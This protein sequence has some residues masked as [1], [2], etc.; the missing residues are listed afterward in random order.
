MYNIVIKYLYTS[1]IDHPWILNS[2][3]LFN[4]GI[5]CN[6]FIGTRYQ[7]RK[8]QPRFFPSM[9]ALIFGVSYPIA[10]TTPDVTNGNFCCYLGKGR[11]G[12]LSK[13]SMSPSSATSFCS[14]HKLSHKT[15]K[16]ENFPNLENGKLGRRFGGCRRHWKNDSQRCVQPSLQNFS[17]IGLAGAL[18]GWELLL[19]LLEE[20]PR[21]LF[22]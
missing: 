20:A 11:K 4:I 8:S 3:P 19:A 10:S 13:K 17:F 7:V 6:F 9:K 16:I 15:L 1:G 12:L 18:Q 14:P 5:S 21:F 2:Y 22:L